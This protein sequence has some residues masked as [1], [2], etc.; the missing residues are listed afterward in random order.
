ML[1]LPTLLPTIKRSGPVAATTKAKATASRSPVMHQRTR[2]WNAGPQQTLCKATYYMD[3]SWHTRKSFRVVMNAVENPA[4][5]LGLKPAPALMTTQIDTLLWSMRPGLTDDGES[6]ALFMSLLDYQLSALDADLLTGI[7]TTLKDARYDCFV[8]ESV[9]DDEMYI[10]HGFSNGPPHT[11]Q[12]TLLTTPELNDRLDQALVATR[13]SLQVPSLVLPPAQAQTLR[14]QLALHAAAWKTS[15]HSLVHVDVM[16]RTLAETLGVTM[17]APLR[18]TAMPI[19]P[20]SSVGWHQGQLVISRKVAE[21]LQH[22][23]SDDLFARVQRD[24]LECLLMRL[25]PEQLT[26][27]G[28]ASPAQRRSLWRTIEQIE[29][30]PPSMV[31]SEE[32]RAQIRQS[33]P[34][35]ENA[36]QLQVMPTV[37]AALGHVWIRPVLSVMPDR[38]V[39]GD[40]IGTR[41]MHGGSYPEASPSTIREWPIRWLSEAEIDGNHPPAEAWHLDLPIDA[42]ALSTG[43]S[44]LTLDW[45][46]SGQRYRFAEVTPDKPASGC[47]IS[48]WESVRRGMTPAIRQCFDEF[49]LGIPL[50]DTPTELW[51]RMR[52]FRNWLELIAHSPSAG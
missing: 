2:R 12:R 37:G 35:G 25:H 20:A 39:Q 33:M 3:A 23:A 4:D 19:A 36:G 49:N 7:D 51:E 26:D 10:E 5:K 48:V 34:A 50:P 43:A 32:R 29:T 8:T 22:E 16:V 38:T 41:Y 14:D 52:S 31:V 30:L 6:K 27:I 17:S 28:K 24:V 11:C 44:E 15:D 40:K 18:H 46:A 21:A 42:S 45:K 9:I 1:S 47:R 13:T